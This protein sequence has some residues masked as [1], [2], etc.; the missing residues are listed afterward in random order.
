MISLLTGLESAAWQAFERKGKV[1]IKHAPKNT[2]LATLHVLPLETTLVA[3]N[4]E[5]QLYSQATLFLAVKKLANDLSKKQSFLF[6]AALT[7][8]LLDIGQLYLN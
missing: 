8:L 6:S 1:G 4:K 2:I 3:N 7:W 5:R